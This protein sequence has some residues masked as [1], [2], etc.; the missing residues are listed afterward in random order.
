MTE[1]EIIITPN[2]E[3]EQF[4]EGAYVRIMRN[5]AVL[6]AVLSVA[7]TVR[8]GWRVGA[9]FALG[10]GLAAI[11]FLWMKRAITTFAGRMV[12]PKAP[13]DEK[14]ARGSATR[15]VARYALVAVTLYVIF[16]SSVVSLSGVL[17]G[18]FLPVAA[19]LVEA[20]YETYA[21]L[22]HRL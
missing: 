19:I 17:I 22:R 15:F 1:S 3:A 8:L 13:G 5:M 12:Q 2:R 14:K 21:A 16:T 9:G 7:A 20:V 10:C 11:N 6:A 4:Y 18:L